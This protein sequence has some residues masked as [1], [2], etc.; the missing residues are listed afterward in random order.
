MRE[1]RWVVA[2]RLLA[3]AFGENVRIVGAVDLGDDWAPVQRLSLDNGTTV[4]VKTRREVAGPWGDDAAAL[5][6]ERRG[7]ALVTELGVDIA[8]RL[9]AADESHI[10]MTDV[11]TGP[12]VQDVL[13]GGTTADA[14]DGLV[15]LAR[16]A[17]ILH[18][19]SVGLEPPWRNRTTF[20]DRAF[21]YWPELRQAAAGLDFPAPLGVSADLE[22]LDSALADPRFRVFVQG[23]LGPNNAVLS[24]GR[25]RL[26]DFEGSGFRHFGLEAANLRLPFPAYGHWAV[27]P[28]AVIAAMDEAYRAELAVGWPGAL[29][30]RTYETGIATGCAVWAIIRAHRLPVIALPGQ[31]P[32][33]ALRRRTQIVQ[34]LTSC[35][36]I[37][38]RA[39]CY[40]A[41][42]GW[43]LAIA[44]AMR[45]RWDNARQP[46]RTFPAF[47]GTLA[48]DA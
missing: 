36:E 34:T 47:A 33:L 40:R 2:E 15:A 6:N 1:D 16:S 5:D 22:A 9:L 29:D 17:G 48:V 26:V 18:A 14:T 23:D 11:G 24:G 30:D 38:S 8:P 20:L 21:E 12:S 19:T 35:A 42:A 13:L 25:A 41:L 4:V 43:F 28:A 37:A 31:D 27:L 10:L 44:D 39:G 7:I 3:A 45:E 32:D 46:P